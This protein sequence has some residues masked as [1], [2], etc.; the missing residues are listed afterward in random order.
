M[1]KKTVVI[2]AAI[3]VFMVAGSAQARS[4]LSCDAEIRAVSDLLVSKGAGEIS[5]RSSAASTVR[6]IR[7]TGR[8][9]EQYV[10]FETAKDLGWPNKSAWT[11][12]RDR[13]KVRP[14]MIGGDPYSSKA[15]YGRGDFYTADIDVLEVNKRGRKRM[16]YNPVSGRIFITTNKYR[17][18]V[19]VRD[20]D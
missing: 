14:V 13:R 11:A 4:R 9:P 10:T 1:M 20:C 6:K 16:V 12:Y 18:L 8:L 19:E 2:S 17:V 5:R 7:K 3:A 15:L